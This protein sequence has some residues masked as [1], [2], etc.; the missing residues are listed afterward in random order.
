MDFLFLLHIKSSQSTR[1]KR[2]YILQ[3][4]AINQYRIGRVEGT[5]Q[6][7]NLGSERNGLSLSLLIFPIINPKGVLEYWN[8]KGES[9]ALWPKSQT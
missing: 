9:T 3:L 2:L 1:V 6:R 7:K 4:S 5:C 8:P